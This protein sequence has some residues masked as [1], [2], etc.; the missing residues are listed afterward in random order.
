MSNGNLIIK[1]EVWDTIPDKDKT[2]IIYDT[3]LSVSTR[4]EKLERRTFFDKVC[5]FAGGVVGGIAG[6]LGV[7][8]L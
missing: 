3:I 1:R 2:W 8:I 4:V 7:K 6:F 5:A